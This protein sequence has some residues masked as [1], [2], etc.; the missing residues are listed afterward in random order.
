MADILTKIQS[1]ADILG[2]DVFFATA[3]GLDPENL[4]SPELLPNGMY[5]RL[6]GSDGSRAYISAFELDKSLN[7]ISNMSKGKANQSDVVALQ[8]LLE[9]KA[10]DVEVELLRTD[11][12]NA[13]TKAELNNVISQLNGK[14]SSSEL[15]EISAAILTKASSED[16]EALTEE[17][18]SKA[19]ASDLETLSSTVSAASTDINAIKTS[20]STINTT[21]ESLTES[22]GSNAV[23]SQIEYLNN[24]LNKK[25]EQDAL[26]PINANIAT[27]NSNIL[28]LTDRLET[29]ESVINNRASKDYVNRQILSIIND[30]NELDEYDI[31]ADNL[32]TEFKGYLETK[33]DKADVTIKANKE[34][35]DRLTSRVTRLTSDINRLSALESSYQELV[36][37][38]ARKANQTTLDSSIANITSNMA[39]K[40]DLS[41][42]LNSIS[43][44]KTQ[45][46]NIETGHD[47][48][49]SSLTEALDNL[50]CNV[51]NTI[52]SFNQL[53]NTQ[54]R[55][56]NDQ[57]TKLAKL[58]T[59]DNELSESVKNEWVRV[60]TPEAY[61]KLSPIGSLLPNGTLDPRAKKANTIYMLVR[62]NKPISVYIGDILI[63]QAEQR[64]ST[65][66]AYTFPITF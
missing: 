30:I 48:D 28:S 41:N 43:L 35:V 26:T 42:A 62:Y 29:A 21:L 3:E 18:D 57:K 49:I 66:F 39:A 50:E 64:G 44:I 38:I 61:K 10:S 51:N 37:T 6:E 47:D 56:L 34:D 46:R 19:T 36:N 45:L 11:I 14:I 20:I 24:E 27:A 2:G 25:L 55:E 60:M 22:S 17:I 12:E 13:A 7:I 31:P 54:T 9:S 5:I 58:E 59:K 65:G 1:T 40:S 32:L 15:D 63:A 16:L 33:A 23:Q 53:L 4:N 52:N 8:K